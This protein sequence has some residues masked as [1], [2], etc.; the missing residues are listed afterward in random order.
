MSK[1]HTG[2]QP[3]S[4]ATYVRKLQGD[5]QMGRAQKYKHTANILWKTPEN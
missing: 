3:S 5:Q 1:W 2:A 4:S